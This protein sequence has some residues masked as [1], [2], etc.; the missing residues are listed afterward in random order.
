MTFQFS[1]FRFTIN[2]ACAKA[3]INAPGDEARDISAV[4]RFDARLAEA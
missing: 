4:Q 3:S 2:P 1:Q